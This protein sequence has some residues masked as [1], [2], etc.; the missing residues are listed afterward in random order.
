VQEYVFNDLDIGQ[1]FKCHMG[2]NSEYSEMWFFYPSIEDGTGEISRYVIFNYEENHWSI[3]SLVRYAWLDAGIEDLP[4]ASATSSSS[5]CVF[6]H[7]IGYDDY[8]DAMTGVFVESADIDISSGDSLTFVKEILPDM[9]FVTEVG[10]SN[11]PAM[12]IVL[13]RRDFPNDSLITD[14]TSQ[15][16][17]STKFKS[18]RTRSRQIVLRFESD[19]DQASVD[20]K[21]YKWRIGSTRLEIQPS[22]RRA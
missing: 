8:E 16:T 2:V 13:K 10:S 1:A 17:Q 12:N 14:S 20:Q 21:G 7:E 11:T 15:I 22:G 3:G 5:Q 18:V 19:D 9:R 6:R 4:F